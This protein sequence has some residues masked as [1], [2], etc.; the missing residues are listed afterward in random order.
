MTP[1]PP[2]ATEIVRRHEFVKND[3]QI[4]TDRLWSQLLTDGTGIALT[5][6]RVF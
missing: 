5:W 4:G 1:S 6:A 3:E 2:T